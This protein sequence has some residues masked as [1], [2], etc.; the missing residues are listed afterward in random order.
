MIVSLAEAPTL[1]NDEA[2]V[3]IMTKEDEQG[4]KP[5]HTVKVRSGPKPVTTAP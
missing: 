4:S 1:G 3:E 2:G 5:T